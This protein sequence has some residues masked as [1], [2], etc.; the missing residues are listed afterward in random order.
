MFLVSNGCVFTTLKNDQKPL[1]KE[2]DKD[3]KNK[4]NFR[5]IEEVVVVKEFSVKFGDDIEKINVPGKATC[6]LCTAV[7]NYGSKGTS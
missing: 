7:I 4:W 6:K 5:W 2:I 1:I 3:V